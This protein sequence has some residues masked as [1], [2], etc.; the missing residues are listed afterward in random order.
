LIG[1]LLGI[2]AGVATALA[3]V[4][5]DISDKPIPFFAFVG[6]V[7]GY[8][9]MLIG[10]AI[11][12]RRTVSD[13]VATAAFP[14]GRSV[15]ISRLNLGLVPHAIFVLLAAGAIA[16]LASGALDGQPAILRHT[17]SAVMALVVAIAFLAAGF[18]L[19]WY[20]VD[21][22]G[23]TEYRMLRRTLRPMSDVA[24]CGFEIGGRLLLAPRIYSNVF[25]IEFRDGDWL[26]LLIPLDQAIP[27]AK[28]FLH[29]RVR[30]DSVA[31]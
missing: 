27:L 9:G 24:R 7:F 10:A 4:R 1:A 6:G 16:V 11:G 26:R 21:S 2:A 19:L 5:K 15:R 14:G 3:L 20:D 28:Q 12:P 13:G 22:T 18:S 25:V 17:A 23:V 8:V 31:A 29:A 30:D